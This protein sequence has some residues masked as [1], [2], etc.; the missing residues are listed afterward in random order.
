MS[1]QSTAAPVTTSLVVDAPA[2]HAFETFTVGIAGWWPASHHIIEAE[3][4]EMVF[5]PWV[6]GHI[7]DRGVDGSECRWATV[8]VYDPPERVV[9][10]WNINLDWKLETDPERTSEVEVRF[11]PQSPARTL[12][13]LEHRHIE[14]HGPGWEGMHEAVAS[15]GGWGGGLGGFAAA[16]RA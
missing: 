16:L 11:T 3:L 8:L 7:L 9:F 1:T 5:E 10:S 2:Q 12:V 14:R 4:A 13:E 6:G 15:P